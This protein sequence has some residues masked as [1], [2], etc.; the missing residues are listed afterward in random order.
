MKVVL[1]LFY[2]VLLTIVLKISINMTQKEIVVVRV[3]P[4]LMPLSKAAY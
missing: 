1:K 4:R 3:S 2:Y